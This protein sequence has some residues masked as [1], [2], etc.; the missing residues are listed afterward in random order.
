MNPGITV[1]TISMMSDWK[2]ICGSGSERTTVI[3]STDAAQ[4]S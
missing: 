3:F 4:L 1:F 2:V